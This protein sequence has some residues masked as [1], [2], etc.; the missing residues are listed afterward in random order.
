MKHVYEKVLLV[1]LVVL[2]GLTIQPKQIESASV[3]SGFNVDVSISPLKPEYEP[4]ESIKIT[5]AFEAKDS[6]V[7]VNGGDTLSIK[8]ASPDT[9]VKFDANKHTNIP[10]K[11]HLDEV[12]GYATITSQGATIT[13]SDQV[14]NLHSLDGELEI[15]GYVRNNNDIGEENGKV[16]FSYGLNGSLDVTIKPGGANTGT[17][18]IFRKSGYAFTEDGDNTIYFCWTLLINEVY[19]NDYTSNIVITDSLIGQDHVYFSKEDLKAKMYLRVTDGNDKVVTQADLDAAGYPG[20]II[21]DSNNSILNYRK[22]KG[23]YYGAIQPESWANHNNKFY[24]DFST[25]EKME[26]YIGVEFK[27]DDQMIITI[28]AEKLNNNFLEVVYYTTPTVA[29]DNGIY[30]NDATMEYEESTTTQTPINK[31]D[32]IHFEDSAGRMSGITTETFKIVKYEDGTTTPIKDVT[33]KMKREDGNPFK[34]GTYEKEVTTDDKGEAIIENLAPGKYIVWEISAPDAYI[35]SNEK[36]TFEMERDGITHTFYNKKKESL[37]IPVEK[38][39][40]D[41]DNAG[42]YRPSEIEVILYAND[43]K[44]DSVKL[45]EDNKWK[46]TFMDLPKVNEEGKDI[47]YTIDEVYVD[48]YETDIQGDM[49]SGFTITNTYEKDDEHGS[50]VLRKTVSGKAEVD[51][52]Y[53]FNIEITYPDNIK[54]VIEDAALRA[55]NT[56]KITQLPFGT[57]IKVIENTKG[58]ITTYTINDKQSQELVIEESKT[59]V[60]IVNNHKPDEPRIPKTGI[61]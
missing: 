46:H 10:L 57:K 60:M 35:I 5:M 1:F 9:K 32:G 51:K 15:N 13:F 3:D 11:N 33:F 56:L 44:V 2:L 36:F 6:S 37:N 26:E 58:Y 14:E 8:W 23:Y 54:E 61:E 21:D 22:T 47:T 34:D 16:T 19:K 49:N 55:N 45:G 50:F 25:T 52:E 29:H 42:G 30:W 39:W 18:E 27:D 38:I 4:N 40:E 7:H 41:N 24:I 43:I 28:P 53:S 48:G 12:L 31:G 17:P 59:Y 20:G